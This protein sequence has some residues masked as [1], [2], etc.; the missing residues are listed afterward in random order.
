MIFPDRGES[1]GHVGE[2]I[3]QNDPLEAEL[4]SI[5]LAYLLFKLK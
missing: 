4:W 5:L 1:G 2:I 3:F